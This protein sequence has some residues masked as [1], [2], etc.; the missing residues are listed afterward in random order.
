MLNWIV[1]ISLRYRGV[2]VALACVLTGYGIYTAAHS[3]LDVLP[4]FVPPEVEV[5]TEAPGLSPEQ[6]EILVTKP[7]ESTINGLGNMASLRS[8]SIS[9]LSTITA[10]FH[11]G[12][13]I[14]IA[15]QMLNERLVET[16]GAL[17][18][19][20][21]R[22]IMSPMTSATMDL[23]KIGLVS[24]NLS[25]MELRSLADWVVKPRMLSIPGVA[26]CIVF[27]G[28]VRQLQIQVKPDQLM[29]H[30]LSINDVVNAARDATGV[31]GAGFIE[32][33]N[34]RVLI[35]AEGQ[36]LTPDAL[37][38]VVI[39][40]SHGQSVRLKDVA[41]VAEAGAPKF[42]DTLI[43]GQHGVFLSMG[44]QYGANTMDVT[45]AVEAAL[46]EMQPL[47][48]REQVQ[49]YPRL[50]RPATFIENSLHNINHSLYLGAVMVA[51]VLFLF[52]GHFR[53]AFISLTAIPLSLLTAIILLDKF[54]VT[55][56]TITIGGLAISIGAVVDDAI[57]DVENIFRRLR[58][59]QALGNPKSNF[60]VTLDA[61]TEVYSAVVYATFIV[62][63]IFL[64]VLTLTGLVGS[65]FA[66]LA[67]SYI[68]AILASLAV[69]L[70]LTP[71]LSLLFFAKGVKHTEDPILQRWVK[72]GYGKILGF[73][74][75]WP[76]TLLGV[77]VVICVGTAFLM[78]S[79]GDQYLPDFREG[80][81]VLQI[82]AI[83][84][85]SLP[86]MLRIAGELT[87]Q[88][89]AKP[90]IDTAEVQIGRAE[91]GEDT[92]EPNRCEFHVE[93]KPNIP[94]KA[95]AKLMDDLRDL[96]DG[97]PGISGEVVTFLGDRISE[98]ITGESAPFV[99]NVYGDDLDVIDDKAR[100]VVRVLQSI[101]GGKNAQVKSPPGA[102]RMAVRLRTERLTQLGFRPMEVLEAVQTAYEGTV[103]A[104]VHEGSKV[105]DVNVILDPAERREPEQIG[106]LLLKNS[107]GA[108]MPLREL[109]D[110]Y[111]TTG[112]YTILHDAASRRQVVTCTPTGRDITSFVDEAKKE[113]MAKVNFPKGVF[114][115]FGGD[116]EASAQAQ[117]E[118]LIHSAIAG[119]GILLLLIVVTRNWRNLL[120]VLANV[121]FAMVGGILAIWATTKFGPPGANAL[122]IGSMV[123]FVTLFGIT[124]RNSIMMVSHF[125]HL[126]NVE[127]VTWGPAAAIRGASER[128]IPILMTALVTALGLLPL[129]MGTGEAGQEIEGPMALVILGGLITSTTLNLLILPTLALRYGKF[130]IHKPSEE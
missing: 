113:V 95:Q 58:E 124:M 9:G 88:L 57:I 121:P 123:G 93:L 18:A 63:L 14:F 42:G 127:G 100:D 92:W 117:L 32:N 61:C 82:Q 56:N 20:V 60:K 2:V 84:G 125:E 76:R 50:H 111:L 45:L 106:S 65:F 94:G 30:G 4:N 68:L 6:V 89:R 29:A 78:P 8:E 71:A 40:Q 11:E 116:A 17:P 46:K 73:I 83:P 12:T 44:S 10:I 43:Q 24:T 1:H 53:T 115:V 101:P 64:P 15:R 62:A 97:F 129:A 107:A 37:G 67:L 25:P 59:N 3:K 39:T 75:R 120:L 110:I 126:V 22:P 7:I 31:V 34:Q 66:P 55:L 99:V 19:G 38:E 47:F 128:V 16:A 28:E 91:Q 27:G 49:L 98:T 51:V 85:T 21:G 112:R 102:P 33:A 23:L 74:T 108:V 90:E 114:A 122:T 103:V 41:L 109:A 81:F 54:G 118:L 36:T 104:Q 86:E 13:D 130:G 79:P 96:L 77:G 87:K 119:A 80:H 72:A 35:L 26:R 105:T 70:T 5:E 48:E 69:A 52:L